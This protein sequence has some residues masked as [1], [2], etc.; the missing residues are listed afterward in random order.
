MVLSVF[1]LQSIYILPRNIAFFINICYNQHI[2]RRRKELHIMKSKFSIKKAIVTLSAFIICLFIGFLLGNF[3]EIKTENSPVV[4]EES[5]ITN[6]NLEEILQPASELVSMKYCYTDADIYERSKEAFGYKVPFTT[7]KVVFTYSGTIS[8]GIEMSEIKYDVDKLT[9]VITVE[10][11]EPK[12]MSHELNEKDFKF[13]DVKNS[14]FTE[15]GLSDYA[16]LMDNL[17]ANK[18]EQLNADAEFMNSVTQNAQVVIR[19]FLLVSE[20]TKDYAI[21]F[22]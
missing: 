1:C 9:K 15:T 16:T 19:D 21:E 4:D 3:L 11:P 6:I 2:F 5:I 12:L 17:K 10:L 14:I 8:A 18:E 7:D 13:Y 20:L 22:K